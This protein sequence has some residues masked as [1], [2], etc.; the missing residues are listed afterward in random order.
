MVRL[1]MNRNP[2]YFSI[3]E[4]SQITGLSIK[5]LR[6]Y[7]EK[8]L[9]PPAVVDSQS[10]YRYYD[11]ASVERARMISRLRELQFPLES[12]AALLA[13][14]TDDAQIL[15]YFSRHLKALQERIRADQQT[16]RML[17]QTIEAE[18]M[19]ARLSAA[20]DFR[21]EE[22]NLG[23]LVVAGYRVKGKYSDSG[24]AFKILAKALGRHISGKPLCLFYDAEFRDEDADFEP[25][26]PMRS[27]VK[28]P[29]GISIR[30]LPAGRVITY[31]HQGPYN[32]LGRS[33]QIVLTE[34]HRRGL[35]VR[36]PSREVYLKGPG[37]IFKGNPNRYLTEIQIPVLQA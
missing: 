11:T 1:T 28:A 32:Q 18:T 31:I 4:F 3:G 16:A 34:A 17:Q 22:R 14:C 12:I 26:F 19:A 15:P 37:M 10:G 7:D 6:F 29:D 21:V 8:G 36:L 5:A 27:Q 33:Y 35:S 24:Q 9:L 2:Q 25:C 23:E 20:S 30:S 13:E